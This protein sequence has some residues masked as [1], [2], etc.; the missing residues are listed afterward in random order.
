MDLAKNTGMRWE[1]E[2]MEN[3]LIYLEHI[4]KSF[5]AV[6]A[7]DDVS[8]RFGHNEIVGLLGDNGAGK[9]TLIKIMSGV[10]RPTK[11]RIYIE[12]KQQEI[13]TPSD[14]I[15][16]GIETVHQS[17]GGLVDVL[18]IERNLFLGREP[19]KRKMGGALAPLNFKRMEEE[20]NTFLEKI[21]IQIPSIKSTIG[22]LSGGQRQSVAIARGLYFGAK[23]LMLDEPTA[24]LGVK[25]CAAL[26]D[27]IKELR[28]H[29]TVILISHN[30]EH[31][32]KVA[33]RA[34]VLYQGRKIKD[35]PLKDL[36]RCQLESL[37]SGYES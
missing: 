36:E 24:P 33:D 12:G 10:E 30:L 1:I 28:N 6:K 4:S 16:L 5:G 22:T 31:I 9:S 27:T 35:A 14:A 37:M 3:S 19:I 32:Y 18:S 25:E 26:L 11:G 2:N 21:G 7:L 13:K 15:R 23:V 8:I 29:L 34:V 17:F 20:T